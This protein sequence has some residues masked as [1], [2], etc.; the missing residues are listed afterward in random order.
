MMLQALAWLAALAFLV[1]FAGMIALH[2]L[3]TGRHP[4]YHTVSDYSLGRYGGLARVMTAVN[5]LGTLCLLLSLRGAAPQPAA[6]AGLVWL[7]ILALSRLGMVF[8]LT[9]ESGTQA[10]ARGL[11]HALLAILSFTAAV[12]ALTTLTKVAA[13]AALWRPLLPALDVLA[14]LAFPLVVLMVLTLV[15]GLRLR[16]VFG[17]MER[18]FLADV[19]LWLLLSAALTAWR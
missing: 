4:L 15:P 18:L 2:F 7:A 11:L 1:Y 10:T 9:D 3:P 8:V 16:R 6:Q 19:S 5:V 13:L 17:L 12:F 14:G